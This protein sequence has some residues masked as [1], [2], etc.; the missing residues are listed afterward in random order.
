MNNKTMPFLTTHFWWPQSKPL[1]HRGSFLS[2]PLSCSRKL[3][4]GVGTEYPADYAQHLDRWLLEREIDEAPLNLG[5]LCSASYSR[6]VGIA[7]ERL[8]QNGEDDT[9]I[10]FATRS[11]FSQGLQH[12]QI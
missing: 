2:P 11:H 7:V 6:S 5:P 10:W 9:R 1:A 12:E 8:M 4:V 3:I